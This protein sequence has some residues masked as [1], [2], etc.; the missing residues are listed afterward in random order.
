MGPTF[1]PSAL[2]R[3]TLHGVAAVLG[4]AFGTGAG[5]QQGAP[6]APSAPAARVTPLPS[7]DQGSR[8]A[9][10]AQQVRAVR[11]ETP[12]A[13]RQ[14]LEVA[15]TRL[16]QAG[17]RDAAAASAIRTRLAN[18]DMRP[19]D[20]FV[21]TLATDS[22]TQREIVVRDSIVVDLP[23]LASLPVRGLLR[24]ELQP[25][26]LQHL[27]RYYRSPEVRVQYLIR[28]GVVGAVAKPGFFSFPPEASLN[29]VLQT[30]GGAAGNAKLKDIT[31]W[32][33]D[34]RLLDKKRFANE[35]R[36]GRTI[37]EIGLRSG[38]EVRVPEKGRSWVDYAWPV[39]MVI[40]TL[41]SILFLIRQLNT[42]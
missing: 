18:G 14:E 4:I 3:R 17:S 34:Q 10:P 38:D 13:T 1:R 22:V 30:A 8:P 42:I 28:V 15:L 31:A 9:S 5:A 2:V 21:M 23:P 27:R 19:G 25:A 16:Q 40:S 7:P 11:A 41:V 26:L 39:T 35:V 32:R 29:D 37:A 20:R 36:G 6:A 12:D 33:Y 24:S